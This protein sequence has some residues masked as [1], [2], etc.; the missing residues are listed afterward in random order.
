VNSICGKKPN[1]CEVYVFGDNNTVTFGITDKHFK[2]KIYVGWNDCPAH[3]VKINI[4][5]N[6]LCNGMEI[7]AFDNNSVVTIGNDCLF[8]ENI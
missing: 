8:G 5:D 6:C 1:L 3:N 7:F 2:A 4:G